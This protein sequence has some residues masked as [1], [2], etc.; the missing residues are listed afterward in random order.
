MHGLCQHGRILALRGPSH[1]VQT[2]S[3][4]AVIKV[5]PQGFLCLTRRGAN[6]SWRKRFGREATKVRSCG[7]VNDIQKY[8]QLTKSCMLAMVSS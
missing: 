2:Q 7:L 6:P 3:R 5:V 1:S 4:Q 8:E